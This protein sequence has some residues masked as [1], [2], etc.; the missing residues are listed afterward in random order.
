[1]STVDQKI[2]DIIGRCR[3]EENLLYINE[4]LDRKTYVELNKILEGFG[5]KW[6]KKLKAH[7]FDECP[8]DKIINII[9]TGE[10]T[11]DKKEWQFYETPGEII[12]KMLSKITITENDLFLE[13]SAGHGAI[14][15]KV[16]KLTGKYI[17]IEKDNQKCAVLVNAGFP[18]VVCC[19]FLE[20]SKEHLC[21]AN[22]E[23]RN[24][25]DVIVMNPPFTKLQDAKHVM[26]AWDLL[27]EHGEIVAIVSES[28]FFRESSTAKQFRE[29]ME[30][31]NIRN[32]PLE[33]GDFKSSGTNVLTRIVWGIKE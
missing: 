13:P 25:V 11:S 27:G 15:K 8:E 16:C 24:F 18:N 26:H 5:G 29:W 30:V 33:H 32:M 20:Y 19:D 9:N 1:M 7:V 12:E 31:N 2:I 21:H 17:A 14:L 10:F 28:C 22:E 23:E 6:D 4:V 3:V